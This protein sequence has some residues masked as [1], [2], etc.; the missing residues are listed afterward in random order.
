MD[1]CLSNCSPLS[2]GNSHGGDCCPQC[3]RKTPCARTC[4]HTHNTHTQNANKPSLAVSVGNK[5]IS[6]V[7]SGWGFPQA[8]GEVLTL[9]ALGI[10]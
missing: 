4:T 8:R 10:R 7:A 1:E 2:V 5:T 9:R 3:S 6:W